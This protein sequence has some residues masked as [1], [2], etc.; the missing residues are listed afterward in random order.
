MRALNLDY[1]IVEL[2]RCDYDVLSD[3]EVWWV[4]YGRASGWK[5]TNHTK[6]GKGMTGYTHTRST[7]ARI[8]STQQQRVFTAEHRAKISRAKRGVSKTPEHRAKLRVATLRQWQD[9]Q[10]LITV[11]AANIGR[12]QTPDV[13]AKR[14]A[15]HVGRKC[16]P[17]TKARMSEA[18]SRRQSQLR[19]QRA[20]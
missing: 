6:G 8:S 19:E 17:E 16:S 15:K 14:A 1:L 20:A 5:L 7:R 10:T 13:I 9:P 3:C 2:E 4:A 18:Q 12:R 11:R